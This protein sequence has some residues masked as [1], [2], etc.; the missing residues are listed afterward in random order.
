L[1][2]NAAQ[3]QA[4]L[5]DPLSYGGMVRALQTSVEA[6][7]DIAFHLCARL[8]ARAPENAADAFAILAE[9]GDVPADFTPMVRRMVGLRNLVV[10]GYLHADPQAVQRIINEHLGDFAAWER[11]VQGILDREARGG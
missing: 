4:K 9:H 2:G 7:I 8:H 10:N 6:M 5:Q 1:A 11:I 3:L